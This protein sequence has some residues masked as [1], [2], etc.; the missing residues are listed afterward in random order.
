MRHAAACPIVPRHAQKIWKKIKPS[1]FASPVIIITPFLTKHTLLFKE[2]LPNQ[3]TSQNHF[4]FSKTH[5]PPLFFTSILFNFLFFL[6]VCC[7]LRV[8]FGFML[9]EFVKFHVSEEFFSLHC[10]HWHPIYLAS[11][12]LWSG[13]IIYTYYFVD[14]N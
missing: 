14:V 7:G 10:N 6:Q 9:K 13:W 4:I 2:T 11:G 12:I 1:V 5:H 3:E 8:D